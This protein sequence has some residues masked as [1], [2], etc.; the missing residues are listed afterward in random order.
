LL[1]LGFAIVEPARAQTPTSEAR[2]SLIF[3]PGL[4]G[5]RL[6][7]PNSATPAEPDVV[8]GTLSA[9]PRFPTIRVAADGAKDGIKPCGLVREIVYL[10]FFR[11]ELYSPILAHLERLGYR[12]G[13]DLFIF[14]YDWRRSVFD[15]GEALARFVN[16]KTGNT[17]R[18][19]IL[20][21][22]M[23]GLIARVYTAK[24]GGAARVGKLVSAGTP[25]LGSVKVYETVEKGWGALNVVMGGLPAFR[26]TILSFPS[27]YELMPRYAGCCGTAAE[28][29]V[30]SWVSGEKWRALGWDGVETAA[31]PNLTAIAV[32]VRELETIIATALPQGVE[33]V[34]L[35]G[36]DQRTPHRATFEVAGGTTIVRVQTTWAGDGTV[37][38]ESAS[39]PRAALHPT[40]FA[41]HERIL[42]DPQV[43]DFLGV[44][45]TRGVAAAVRTVPVAPRANMPI[46]GGGVAE[47]VGIVIE[48][49]EPIYRAGAKAKLYVHVRLGTK[50]AVAMEAIKVTARLPD[51]RE[52]PVLLKAD[53]AASDPTNPFEQSFAGEFETG[54]QA[55]TAL[56]KGVIAVDSTRPRVIER[57]V[58][59]VGR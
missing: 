20:A 29:P 33:D 21:H 25:F 37:V 10:G 35:V 41:E 15:N 1:W 26:R 31:M 5:S 42:N 45:L 47:L 51:G 22:S 50:Q 30:F 7:R 49:R 38:R 56:L 3:V 6:C 58:A 39:I 8:W 34:A 16:E 55:G 11:L 32:R 40:R 4:L 23:G 17:A 9:L 14:D 43:Q 27:V 46:A 59:I 24:F 2:N 13:R 52:L 57:P 19:D 44:A 18:V 48:P 28:A 53:K 36:I 12:E 54:S